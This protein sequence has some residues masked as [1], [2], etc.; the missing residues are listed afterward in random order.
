MYIYII[1]SKEIFRIIHDVKYEKKFSNLK[2]Q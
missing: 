1:I 2:L